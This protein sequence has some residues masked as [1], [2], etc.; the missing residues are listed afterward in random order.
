MVDVATPVY[1][2]PF[3]LLLQLILKEQVD[4]YEVNLARIVDAY[5]LEIEKMQPRGDP[6]P[7][8]DHRVPP[9]R[10]DAASI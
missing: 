10:R 1:E 5:L 7:R 9:D 4:I 3:D 8:R 2:G 6:R